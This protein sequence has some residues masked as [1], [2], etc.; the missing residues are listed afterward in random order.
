ML[1]EAVAWGPQADG[2]LC[3]PRAVELGDASVWGSLPSTSAWEE[4]LLPELNLG[5]ALQHQGSYTR[6]WQCYVRPTWSVRTTNTSERLLY[7]DRLQARP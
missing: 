7:A 1:P 4:F 2:A 5:L 6:R 3:S